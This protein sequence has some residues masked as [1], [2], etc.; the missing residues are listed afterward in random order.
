MTKIGGGEL[1]GF[2]GVHHPK[3]MIL[4]AVN[5]CAGYSVSFARSTNAAE[6]LISCSFH[7]AKVAG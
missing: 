5:F 2:K 3:S 7:R 1:T 4:N 6:S